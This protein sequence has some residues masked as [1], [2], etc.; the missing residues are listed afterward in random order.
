MNHS[1]F[2]KHY[3]QIALE[4]LRKTK[5]QGDR[6]FAQ[7]ADD[8]Y[9]RK[10]D[11][12]SNNIAHIIQHITGNMRSRWTNFL[13]TDGEKPDRNRDSE[14]EDV[15]SNKQELMQRWE[16]GWTLVLNTVGALGEQDLLKTVMIRNEP[17][18]VLQAIQRQIRHYAGH[19]DQIVLL[20]RM[21][22]GKDWRSLS[23]PKKK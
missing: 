1:E 16:S 14:F 19:V 7:L 11:S 3:L 22:K 5:S 9:F 20:A 10:F 17:H 15:V 13:T 8:D 12:E 4:D 21:I 18:T 2:G 23:I 6:T